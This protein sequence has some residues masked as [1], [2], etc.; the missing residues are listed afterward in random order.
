MSGDSIRCHNSVRGVCVCVV[1]VVVVQSLSCVRLFAT[2]WTVLLA[3]NEYWPG[4]LLNTL[5]YTGP[6][7]TTEN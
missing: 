7:L 3:S 2:L 1:V 6:P 5:Q 4:M